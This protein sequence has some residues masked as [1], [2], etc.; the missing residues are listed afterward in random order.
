MDRRHFFAT[1]TAAGLAVLMQPRTASGQ[2]VQPAE[3]DSPTGSVP[4]LMNPSGTGIS[5]GW[6]M[7]RADTMGWVEYGPSPDKLVLMAPAAALGFSRKGR[8]KTARLEGLKPGVTCHYRVCARPFG[9]RDHPGWHGETYSFVP[10]GPETKDLTFA[11]INDTHENKPVI[12]KLIGRIHAAKPHFFCWNGD[13]FDF[14]KEQQ[15]IDNFYRAAP[16][17][18]AVSTPMV[19]SRGNHDC[20]GGLA[21]RLGDYVGRPSSDGFFH[22]FRVGP[23]GFIVLDTC[24]D[25]ADSRLADGVRFEQEIVRQ[26]RY[27]ETLANDPNLAG[28]KKRVLLCHIPLWVQGDWAAP[29]LRDQW[30]ANLQ[31]LKVDL[32]ISGHVHRHHFL[33]KGFPAEKLKHETYDPN[34]PDVAIPQL[35][36]GGPSESSATLIWGRWDGTRLHVKVENLEGKLLWEERF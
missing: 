3:G 16:L 12:E 23:V 25:K 13:L 27:L 30:L 15:A 18:Y 9:K 6:V 35:I 34:P 29:W 24:E 10:T 14:G 31:A 32:I 7:D 4:V 17:P 28:A 1:G 33:P 19:Y 11:V 21:D 20:R 5:V 36:G 22:T 2:E 8:V 26:R